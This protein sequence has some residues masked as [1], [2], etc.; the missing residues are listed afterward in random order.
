MSKYSKFI[1]V[2]KVP[3]NYS[4]DL[5]VVTVTNL[6]KIT[7]KNFIYSKYLK[8]LKTTNVHTKIKGFSYLKYLKVV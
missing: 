2:S 6:P 8:V 5:R 1:K 3:Q 7:Q 4:N